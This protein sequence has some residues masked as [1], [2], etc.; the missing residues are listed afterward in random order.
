MS[1]GIHHIAEEINQEW[2]L[3]VPPA[4]TE[5]IL[6]DVLAERINH[7]IKNDLSK[8]IAILYRIDVDEY[9]LKSMLAQYKNVNAGKIVAALVIDRQKQKLK[10]KSLFTKPSGDIDEAEKW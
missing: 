1:N 7:L 9:K 8:L 6:I 10:T 2:N 4:I 5:E 3:S